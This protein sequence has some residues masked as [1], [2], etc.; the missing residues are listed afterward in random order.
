MV[1]ELLASAGAERAHIGGRLDGI[2][3]AVHAV[4]PTHVEEAARIEGERLIVP[5]DVERI[6]LIGRRQRAELIPV[7]PAG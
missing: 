1:S 2:A 7:G 4:D 5:A 6:G 3:T